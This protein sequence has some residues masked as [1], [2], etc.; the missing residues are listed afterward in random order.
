MK[1]KRLE[2]VAFKSWLAINRK[3]VR[4]AYPLETIYECYEEFSY[5][6]VVGERTI[7]AGYKMAA[8]YSNG[9][10]VDGLGGGI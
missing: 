1:E 10:V 6:A 3:N 7:N 4:K 5:N 9:A 2:H 8:T